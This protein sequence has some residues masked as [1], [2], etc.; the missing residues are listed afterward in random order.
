MKRTSVLVVC[1]CLFAS[2]G[3]EN[4]EPI[5]ELSNEV[6][7]SKVNNYS[8]DGALEIGSTPV[9]SLGDPSF[10]WSD[11]T[12][13]FRGHELDPVADIDQAAMILFANLT[14]EEVSEGLSTD[15]IDQASVTLYVSI[16]PGSSTSVRLSE[17]T[18]FG[19]DVDVETY[20]EEG[21][22]TWLFLLATGT[23]PAVGI[24]MAAFISPRADESN[25]DVVIENE[26]SILDFSV[27]IQSLDAAAVP[28]HRPDLIVDWS[29]VTEDGRGQTISSGEVDR[30]LVGYYAG[31]DVSDLEEQILDLELIADELWYLDIAAVTNQ[32]LSLLESESGVFPGVD[33]SG[34][35]ILV[36]QCMTCSNPAPPVLTVLDPA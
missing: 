17:L 12:A 26:S 20:L 4:Q 19:N 8:Y 13:D 29:G 33:D 25:S 1:L 15:S 34:I 28:L 18:L 24:R 32:D 7:L 3:E 10:D 36:L 35:W 11:L 14:E 23:T 6:F 31:L 22:G 9:A 30:V 5:V 27:D 21:S 16:D 2:C